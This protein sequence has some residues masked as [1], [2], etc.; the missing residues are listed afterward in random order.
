MKFSKLELDNIISEDGVR[1]IYP[2]NDQI[3]VTK[4]KLRR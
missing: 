1:I 2:T 3:L 4:S